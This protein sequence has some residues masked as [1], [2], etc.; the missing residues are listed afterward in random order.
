MLI[1]LG[2]S[3]LIVIFGIDWPSSE[4]DPSTPKLPAQISIIDDPSKPRT[5]VSDQLGTLDKHSAGNK[6]KPSRVSVNSQRQPKTYPPVSKPRA[7]VNG[8]M[9]N[10]IRET[11]EDVKSVHQDYKKMLEEVQERNRKIK[12]KK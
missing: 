9:L 12:T 1:L 8:Q 7:P 10:E 4:P 5:P 2:I 3:P 11:R 6:G